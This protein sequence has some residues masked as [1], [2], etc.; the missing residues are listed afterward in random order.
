MGFDVQRFVDQNIDQ[1]FICNICHDVLEDPLMIS[2]C[3]HLY[4]SKCI[5]DCI[6]VH[7]VCPQD[8]SPVSIVKLVEPIRLV[9]NLI[10]KLKIRCKTSS[11][12]CD[13]VLTLG[14][15]HKHLDKCPENPENKQ[16]KCFCKKVFTSE[17]FE[18]HKSSCLEY[19]QNELNITR[20]Q[21]ATHSWTLLKTNEAMAE[22]VT[23]DSEIK[24]L[25]KQ[26]KAS[27]S[28]N[29]E[30]YTSIQTILL[31]V[32]SKLLNHEISAEKEILSTIRYLKYSFEDLS[33]ATNQNLDNCSDFIA[34]NGMDFLFLCHSSFNN[35]Y[36]NRF[37]A[38]IVKNL[39]Q[40]KNILVEIMNR[41]II[42]MLLSLMSEKNDIN[43]GIDSA[44]V[45]S[46]ITLLGTEVWEERIPDLNRRNM[47]I[48]FRSE[49]YKWKYSEKSEVVFH[50]LK[51]I[52]VGMK[53]EKTTQEIN[54]FY[55][56]L[57]AH[58]IKN[59]PKKYIPMIDFEDGFQFLKTLNESQETAD[60]VK[61]HLEIIFN[62]RSERKERQTQL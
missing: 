52:F 35:K 55:T 49:V 37:V 28:H 10:N 3:Q 60:Y 17:E 22:K 5:R 26:L 29:S 58:L 1:E 32:C 62:L 19:H 42:K 21:L 23:T 59:D 18:S 50:S 48:N 7:G 56:W 4:C 34:L 57:L 41:K 15:L 33:I 36:I 39:S 45:L 12:G 8:R 27:L 53:S 47:L 38:Q 40:F 61:R 16:M 13:S 9:K 20:G 30:E 11:G 25:Y 14:E 24:F 6:K 46:S 44:T 2:S 31:Y 43:V 51:E 54:A